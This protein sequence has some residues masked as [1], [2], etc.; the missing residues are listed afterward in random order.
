MNRP[1]SPDDPRIAPVVESLQA[2]E[3]ELDAVQRA[4]L[5]AARRRALSPAPARALAGW[6]AP[7]LA[8]GVL[9]AVGLGVWLQAPGTSMLPAV[10]PASLAAGDDE[11]LM[12]EDSDYLLWLASNDAA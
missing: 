2:W 6:L 11:A 12:E 1:E 7:A 5:A 4:R 8:A 9:M 10:T 3:G